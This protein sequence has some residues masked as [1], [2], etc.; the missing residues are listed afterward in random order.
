MRRAGFKANAMA[1]WA[2]PDDP[3]G[4]EHVGRTMAGFRAVTLGPLVLRA[5]TA[6]LACVV[7]TQVLCQR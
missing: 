5:E 4:I 1:V 6:A 2:G 7:A 3:D